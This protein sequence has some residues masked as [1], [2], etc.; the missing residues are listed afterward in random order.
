MRACLIL[1]SCCRYDCQQ[2]RETLYP[3]PYSTQIP[4]PAL[5][6]TT[7][8][9]DGNVSAFISGL[10]VQ[11]RA[12][13]GLEYDLFCCTEPWSAN[14]RPE[15]RRAITASVARVVQGGTTNSMTCRY[16][17]IPT[18]A[19]VSAEAYKVTAETVRGLLRDRFCGMGDMLT[20]GQ[21][22]QI[23]VED[24]FPA[25]HIAYKNG[26]VDVAIGLWLNDLHRSTQ[27]AAE[28]KVR[29][30]DLLGRT[31]PQLVAE[32]GDFATLEGIRKRVGVGM[33]D[34]STDGR[35]MSLFALATCAQRS[36][37]FSPSQIGFLSW[38]MSQRSLDSS[39]HVW[40][41]PSDLDMALL[42]GHLD[43]V[44]ELVGRNVMTESYGRYTQKAIELGRA[45]MAFC[46]MSGLNDPARTTQHEIRWLVCAARTKLG[47]LNSSWHSVSRVDERLAVDIA[48]RLS[49]FEILVKNLQALVIIPPTRSDMMTDASRPI[50]WP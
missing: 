24:A 37:D 32:T 46:F 29:N 39:H 25:S 4:L 48:C 31:F 23:S 6:S 42:S 17:N 8:R 49:Q 45:D 16:G 44:R 11:I 41:G 20:I 13:W 28:H 47:E 3:W 7:L 10:D 5:K 19:G 2:L 9:D 35:G 40:P 27:N 30:V 15:V 14:G 1:I 33:L 38:L 50:L 43:I 22:P 12:L 34:T 36:S 26:D 18:I 21:K